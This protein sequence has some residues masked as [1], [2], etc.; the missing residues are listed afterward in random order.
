[1]KLGLKEYLSFCWFFFLFLFHVLPWSEVA[2]FFCFR[3]EQQFQNVLALWH[4]SHVNMKSVVSWH[5]LT[6]EI[7]AVRAGN[8]ASVS[9]MTRKHSL[10]SHRMHFS[11]MYDQW[12]AAILIFLGVAGSSGQCWVLVQN[13]LPWSEQSLYS[14]IWGRSRAMENYLQPSLLLSAETSWKQWTVTKFWI[15]FCNRLSFCIYVE[16][17]WGD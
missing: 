9:V 8:V 7:E 3:I 1:M 2:I 12:F 5:Y 11:E 17:I 6:N 15:F 14:Y 10:G 16:N 13:D 4:E